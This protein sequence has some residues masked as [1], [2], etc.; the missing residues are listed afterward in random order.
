MG[1]EK[2][3]RRKREG[4]KRKKGKGKKRREERKSSIEKE[5]DIYIIHVLKLLKNICNFVLKG[6]SGDKYCV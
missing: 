2:E 5:I 3:V 6:C 4:E 1:K